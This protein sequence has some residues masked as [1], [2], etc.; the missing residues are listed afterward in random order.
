MF[1]ANGQLLVCLRIIHI[2]LYMYSETCLK[3]NL[4]GTNFCVRNRHGFC[5]YMLNKPKYSALGFY[6]FHSWLDMFHDLYNTNTNKSQNIWT[7]FEL[8]VVQSNSPLIIHRKRNRSGQDLYV[9]T[10]IYERSHL[11][12]KYYIEISIIHNYGL[13]FE[14]EFIDTFYQYFQ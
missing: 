4:L 5:F 11:S 2:H 1:L 10:R 9:L 6:L 13:V 12:D 14:F 8:L 3:L 7:S